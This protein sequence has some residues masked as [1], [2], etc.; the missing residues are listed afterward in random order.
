ME[1][2][3]KF[4]V[5]SRIVEVEN[6]S[7]YLVRDKWD[8][9]FTYETMFGVVFVDAKGC[10]Y[11]FGSVKIGQINQEG[12]TPNLPDTF[13]K[14]SNEFF[15]IGINEYYYEEIRNKTVRE[16]L[17]IKLRD[18]SFD[19]SIFD[20]VRTLEVTRISLLRDLTETTIRGQ[21]NRIANGGARL[22][23]YNFSYMLPLELT[24]EEVKKLSFDVECEKKPPTN[25]HVLI[26]K[27]GVGKTTV[28][29]RMLYAVENRGVREQVG[30]FKGDKFSNVVFVSFSAFDMSIDISDLTD[31]T[32]EIPY[33]FVR[34][35]EKERIKSGKMLADDF[36]D[37]LYIIVR[38]AKKHLWEKAIDILESDSTFTELEV[39]RWS[40][41]NGLKTD[42]SNV[43]EERT[44]GES[45][46]LY[47]RR[48]Q[49]R[50]L[51]EVIGPKFEKLSSGHKVILL[52]IAKLVQLVEEKT[53]VLLD[54]P[55]EHLHPPLVSAFIRALSDLLIYR[56]G[57]GIVATHSPVIVQ[58]VPKKC[59]WILRRWGNKITSERPRI[60]TF[61]E[62]LGELTS[63]IFGYEVTNSGFHKMIQETAQK[64]SSYRS[65]A[66]YFNNELGKEA[67][68]ILKSYM[69]EKESE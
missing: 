68:S 21:F 25:I 67:R 49:R 65:A 13:D 11:S 22:T 14:L 1:R 8:D 50:A 7:V 9:W 64:K 2:I 46:L 57:V 56:N 15:S 34:L 66:K 43:S 4:H 12:R 60:E 33:T 59:V 48:I 38:G 16:E 37:S 10:Q 58:E 24:N 17:L 20:D 55:E 51:A 54:E 47:T 26:G 28:L 32:L 53:L 44:E 69:Y 18:I 45:N 41:F 30:Q 61:G 5:V 40:D 42:K 63:E 3:H 36:V 31:D 39:K 35:V 62:N 29:K 6:R 19:L 23:D 27:N 52:T